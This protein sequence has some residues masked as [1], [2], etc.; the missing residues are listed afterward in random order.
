MPHFCVIGG[1]DDWGVVI[2]GNSKVDHRVTI[3]FHI[4]LSSRVGRDARA[5]VR[6]LQAISGWSRVSDLKRVSDHG[7]GIGLLLTD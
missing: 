5:M 7:I 3:D 2:S 4:P 1:G 6:A